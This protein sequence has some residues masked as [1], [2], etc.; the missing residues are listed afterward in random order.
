MRQA[1]GS[2]AADEAI[3]RACRLIEQSASALSLDR[4]ASETGMSRDRFY[5]LFIRTVGI[6]PKA[7][8][9]ALRRGRLQKAL[10]AAR[11]VAEAVFD[12]GYG[13]GS[14]VYEKPEALL[15]MTPGAYRK[16]AP[17]VHIRCAIA[18]SALGWLLV[19][20][21]RNGICMIEF[22][23]SR[24]KLQAKVRDRFPDAKLQT[25]DESLDQWLQRI[26]DYLRVPAGSL[27]LPLDVQGTAFQQRVWQVL[28]GIPAGQ[29]LTYAQVAQRI[30]KPAAVRAVARAV[31]SNQVAVAIPCHRVIGS[32]GK[33]HGYR[34]GV[35]RKSAL[36]DREHETN[37]RPVGR[38]RS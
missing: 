26:V 3:V 5:R 12:A 22:G 15:G 18:R 9:L 8:S 17:G 25:S 24:H 21:S 10:P 20:A 29:T 37:I 13:S 34:W 2:T 16:G 30:G 11:G 27:D 36:L 32:D 38:K 7:Y 31:A 28:Q 4:L 33:L 14:R 35:E 19:A 6:T 23:D 1:N